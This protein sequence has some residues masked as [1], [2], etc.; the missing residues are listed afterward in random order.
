MTKKRLTPEDIQPEYDVVVIGAGVSGLTSAALLS[1]AGLS[2]LVLERDSR[3]GGYLAGFRRRHFRFDSAIHWLNQ[4]GENGLGSK[5]FNFIGSD[6]PKSPPQHKIRRMLSDS[7]D[8]LLTD[9]PDKLME[10]FIRDF[11]ED[12]RGIR[13]FFSDARQLSAFFRRY[14]SMFRTPES[15]SLLEKIM[16]RLKQ[17]MYGWPFLKHI[18]FAGTEGVEKGLRKYFSNPRLRSYFRTE[19]DILGC[20]IPIAWAY[21]RDFQ[22]PPEG[23]SLVIPE[24]LSYVIHFHGGEIMLDSLV[25]KINLENGEIRGI[26][27]EYRKK[28]ANVKTNFILAACDVEMLYEKLLPENA[29]SQQLKSRLRKADLYK[30]SVTVSLS[31]DCPAEQFGF[32]EEMI[33]LLEDNIG[34]TAHASGDPNTGM[35]CVIA[36]TFRDPTLAP[37]GKGMLTIY[38]GA[39]IDYGEFWQTERDENGNYQRGEAYK[40]FKEEYARKLIRRVEEKLAPGLSDHIVY[41]D[42]ATPVTHWRYTGNRNGSIMGA[43]PGEKNMKLKLAHHQTEVPGLVLGGH[44]SD[45]GGGVP[46]A[47]KTGAN[48][49]LLIL[50]KHNKKA[51]RT[52][53]RYIDGKLD[54]VVDG[55]PGF[56]LYDDSWKREATPAEERAQKN[57]VS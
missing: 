24:W 43:V 32:G 31:L 50:K 28:K 27:F 36:P 7:I 12:E 9:N 26:E 34:R 54:P 22:N 23:G 39:T 44:W 56:Q 33:F 1:K 49:A 17:G 41:M 37:E 5:I 2:V 8:Y 30:S 40:A 55:I 57:S 48:S 25:K 52:L 6:Y 29:I 21:N 13:W 47:I 15:M 45:Y 18:R 3:P 51:F 38:T 42:V 4:M 14:P 11:P 46:I 53:A 20:L 16:L 35:M 10:A 19:D